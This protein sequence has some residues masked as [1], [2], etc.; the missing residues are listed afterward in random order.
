LALAA[1]GPGDF[2]RGEDPLGEPAAEAVKRTLDTADV[3]KIG[4]DAEDHQPRARST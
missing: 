3:A 2:A 4:A 1:F